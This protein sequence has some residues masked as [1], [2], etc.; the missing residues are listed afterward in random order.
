[1]Q[2]KLKPEERLILA[3]DVGSLEELKALLA[4]V[5]KNIGAIKLGKEILTHDL[6]TGEGIVKCVLEETNFNIM[7]DLKYNDI[8]DTVAG[9]AK[10][11]A[12]YGQGRILGFTIHCLAG[13]RAM[14]AAVKAVKE[15]FP[16]ELG[17]VPLVIGVTVLTSLAESDLEELGILE[18]PKEL[19]LR[20]A[21]LAAKAG[22][23]AI[24]S[25]AQE[26]SVIL[27]ENPNFIVINP[28]IRF[29]GSDLKSQK[30]VTTPEEA[31]RNGASYIVMGS[32]IRKG[33]PAANARRAV[34]E[35]SCAEYVSLSELDIAAEFERAGAIYDD[36]HFV[37]K[38]GGHGK[39]YV[40][41][42]EIYKKPEI[43]ER[44][45][46]EIAYRV[47]EMGI[48]VVCGP[49]VGGALVASYIAKA[50]QRFTGRDVIAVF[51]DE[52]NGK[53]VLK[54][55]YDKHVVGKRVMIGEDVI[56]TGESAA[57]TRTAVQ[58]AGGLAVFC[59]SLC[60][61]S[62]N[63]QEASI[64]IGIPA[65]TLWDLIMDNFLANQCPR[66]ESGV[67]INQDLGHGKKYLAELSVTDLEKAKRLGYKG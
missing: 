14:E 58:I 44:L 36:N 52:E 17:P 41:K 27:R 5:G 37:Y 54:R 12:K 45:C 4:S 23:P 13:R 30:R 47:R 59:Y 6:L 28:G 33:D 66:C 55:G 1:M 7:W 64:I 24:V 9:A 50:L 63:K 31:V 11:V 57:L 53:R 65:D 48:E 49:T 26:T 38:A 62:A 3:A 35:I 51:A 42:D 61:R 39:A 10:E 16:A 21:K 67:P 60:N 40:N 43:L 18:S 19:V 25:S 22:V 8:P 29:R 32:D 46:T 2:L 20:L 34:A 15:N 56:N